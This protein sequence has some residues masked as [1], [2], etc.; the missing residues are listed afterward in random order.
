[1]HRLVEMLQHRAAAQELAEGVAFVLGELHALAGAVDVPLVV[2][3]QI[4][5]A[6]LVHD[7]TDAAT[8]VGLQVE[9]NPHTGQVRL[10]HLPHHS[11]LPIAVDHERNRSSGPR[12]AFVMRSPTRIGQKWGGS[13]KQLSTGRRVGYLL[14]PVASDQTTLRGWVV[15]L[16]T[17]LRGDSVRRVGWFSLIGGIGGMGR[18]VGLRQLR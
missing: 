1:M 12:H 9:A 7:H 4:T 15:R 18:P 10:C 5:P 16:H 3:H 8:G 6:G 17:E 13:L 11:L 14:R 2:D